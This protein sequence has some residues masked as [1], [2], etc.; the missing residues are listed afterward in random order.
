M[1][2]DKQNKKHI[3]I[4]T[5]LMLPIILFLIFVGISIA[6]IVENE[7]W[8]AIGFGIATILPIGVFVISPLY[9]VFDDEA[10]K[11]VYN[12]GQSLTIPWKEIREIFLLGSWIGGGI[13]RYVI[14]FPQRDK[15]LFFIVG[16][17]SKTRRTKKL[18]KSYYKGKII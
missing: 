8:G 15:R 10:A 6:S 5:H 13:P 2:I 3:A 4:N 9:F 14:S 17:I 1:K 11:I 7:L 16:E 12:F 18:I